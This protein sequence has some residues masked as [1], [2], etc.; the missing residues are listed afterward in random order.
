MQV[1]CKISNT[2][3]D[4]R[5]KVCGQ[6]FLVYWPRTSRA[7]QELTRR[8]VS[9]ALEQQH[10]ASGG[11]GGHVHPRTGFTVPDWNGVQAISDAA[12]LSGAAA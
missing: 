9:E 6:G 8:Q 11:Q 4:V 2:V 7:E 3:S 10:A 5:C 12:E 1:L